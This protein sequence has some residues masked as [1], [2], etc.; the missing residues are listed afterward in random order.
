MEPKME[1][2]VSLAF[3]L[4]AS[5]AS[6]NL[7]S[8][9]GD[10]VFELYRLQV[11]QRRVREMIDKDRRLRQ[12][13]RRRKAFLLPSVTAALSFFSTTTNR[14]VWVRNCGSE[15]NFWSSVE[16]FDDDERKAQFRVCRATFDHLLEQVGPLIQRRGTNFR[17]AGWR[18]LCGGSPEPESIGLSR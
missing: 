18:S 12:D 14:H 5:M 10:Q 17:G 7:P 11:Q 13:L 2:R 9:C 8:V 1:E 4:L 6:L 15:H 16:L 3:A